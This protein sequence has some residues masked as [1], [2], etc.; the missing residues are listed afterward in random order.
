MDPLSL[1][2]ARLL[3]H[4]KAQ[5]LSR[6]E[7]L[8]NLGLQQGVDGEAA[9]RE[10]DLKLSRMRSP[11]MDEALRAQVAASLSEHMPR[12]LEIVDP[13]DLT[14]RLREI[15]DASLQRLQARVNAPSDPAGTR[16]G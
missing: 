13:T 4:L 5:G 10:L 16:G 14:L 6:E 1:V 12:L 15:A 8:Q 2:D 7:I 9:K 11:Q 3:Q